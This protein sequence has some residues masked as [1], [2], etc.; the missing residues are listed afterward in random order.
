MAANAGVTG[1]STA[2]YA[3]DSKAPSVVNMALNKA[4]LKAGETGALS[5]TF[6]EAVTGLAASDFSAQGGALSNLA[7][8]DGGVNWTAL[9]TPTAS[10]ESGANTIILAN[11]SYTD[12]FGNAGTGA[13][14]ASYSIDTKVPVASVTTAPEAAT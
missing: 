7:S 11:T 9:F 14:T 6:S 4:S 2:N 5:L 8:S 12:L 3:V 13:A 1:A 10:I